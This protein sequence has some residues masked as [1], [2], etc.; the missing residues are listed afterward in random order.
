MCPCKIISHIEVAVTNISSDPTHKTKT[1]TEVGGTL[2][3]IA[4]H[5][6]QSNYLANQKQGASNKIRFDSVS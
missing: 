5:L 6:D 3:R 2:V 1:A 4:T